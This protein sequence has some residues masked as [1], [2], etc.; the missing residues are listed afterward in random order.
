MRHTNSL[1]FRIPLGN[2]AQAP[3]AGKVSIGHKI[4]PHEEM[5]A[6][7]R[8]RLRKSEASS[9]FPFHAM[10]LHH[11]AHGPTEPLPPLHPRPDKPHERKDRFDS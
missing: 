7:K 8:L 1:P 5:A 4:H 6:P 2:G 9:P 3:G 10:A 11:E